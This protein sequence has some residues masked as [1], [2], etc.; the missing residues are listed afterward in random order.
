MLLVGFQDVIAEQHTLNFHFEIL[1]L[2]RFI[3]EKEKNRKAKK[4]KTLWKMYLKRKRRKKMRKA[5]GQDQF[6]KKI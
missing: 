6:K 1:A 3:K 2:I 5:T 4:T